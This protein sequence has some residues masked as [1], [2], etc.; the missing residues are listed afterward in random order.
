MLSATPPQTTIEEFKKEGKMILR[1]D[2][3]F[4]NHPLP[5]P[6]IVVSVGLMKYYR[7][8][9]VLQRFSMQNKPVFIFTPTIT[10]PWPI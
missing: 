3:R 8:M 9:R 10:I 5:V 6:E 4:H 1:L 2:T 7:L